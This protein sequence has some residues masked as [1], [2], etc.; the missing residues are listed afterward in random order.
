MLFTN[1]RANKSIVIKVLKQYIN[2][3]DFEISF[4]IDKVLKA[5][6][7]ILSLGFSIQ[8]KGFGTLIPK[9]GKITKKFDFK[10]KKMINR[11][12]KPTIKFIPSIDLITLLTE[13]QDKIET[14]QDIKT[15]E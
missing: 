8:L 7:I 2:A 4:L 12:N 14:T 11:K 15:S 3:S 6:I 13:F 9:Q 10:S 1:K 5:L